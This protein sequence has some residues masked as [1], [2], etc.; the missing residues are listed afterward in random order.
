[1]VDRSRMTKDTR[2]TRTAGLRAFWTSQVRPGGVQKLE[3][4]VAGFDELLE[5]GLPE[6]RVT[7]V[8]GGPG[9]GKT[10]LLNEF[11]YRG[12]RDYGQ[13]GVFVT[14]EERPEDIQRNLRNF[15]WELDDL[16][17]SERVAFIDAAPHAGGEIALGEADWF[18]PML[19]RIEYVVN[20]I[21]ARRLAVDNLGA[22]FLRYAGP[23]D[24]GDHYATRDRLFRFSDRLRDLGVTTL[25]S[26]ESLNQR[27]SLSHYN[28]DEFVSQGLIELSSQGGQGIEVRNMMVR[29]L[30]GCGYRSGNVQFEITSR[31]LE[32]FP[33]IPVDTSV[34]D[35]DFTQRKTFGVAELDRALGGGLPEGHILLIAGNTGTGKTTLGLQFVDHGLKDGDSCVWVA[36]EEP[37]SVV[38]RSA[39]RHGWNLGPAVDEGRLRFVT[40][41]V[42]D[43]MPDRL[44]Y[45]ILDAVSES[46]AT[47]IVVDS[48]SSLESASLDAASARAFMLQLAGFAK[49][50]GLTVVLNYLSNEIFGAGKGQLLASL[51][52]NELRLSSIVDGVILLRYVERERSVQKLLNVLKLRG[53]EHDKRIFHYE[54]GQSGF[55]MGEQFGDDT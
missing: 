30:R 20:K 32:V 37:V 29:K 49:T 23:A 12:A 38:V 54:I 47:R 41:P 43:L 6:G 10:V 27:S 39:A 2:E 55:V 22:M 34:G 40:S 45:H 15:D 19:A 24:G 17:E 8:S 52:S 11:I 44:L 48:A 31:G 7:L 33:K 4:G 42:L 35:T 5:G 1:M 14:F 25:I 50:R 3:T 36:L 51:N 53:S 16:V 28:V 26:T 21:G 46:G 9:C 13:P 18:E